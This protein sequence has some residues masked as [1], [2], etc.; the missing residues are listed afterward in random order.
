MLNRQSVKLRNILEAIAHLAYDF[1]GMEKKKIGDFFV[2]RKIL[3]PE[4]KSHVLDYAHHSGKSFGE[5]G[6]ELGILSRDDMIKVFGPSFEIDFFYLDPKYFPAVT[7]EALSVNE[8]LRYGAL[9][10]GFK[11]KSGFLSQKKSVNVGFL[12]PGNEAN[13]GSVRDLLL[14]RLAKDGVTDIKIF[15]ILSDQYMDVL[16]NSY[17]KDRQFLQGCDPAELDPVLQLHLSV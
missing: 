5:A 6:L 8:I 1:S 10:L 12:D 4:E 14:S 15:L 13:V 3:T 11:R 9:P 7:K 2:E 16:R 17:G